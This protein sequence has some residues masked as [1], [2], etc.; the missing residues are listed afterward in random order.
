MK[1]K[2]TNRYDLFAFERSEIE[3]ATLTR[4]EQHRRMCMAHERTVARQLFD[5]DGDEI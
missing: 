4:A 3:A 5:F 2:K 1:I